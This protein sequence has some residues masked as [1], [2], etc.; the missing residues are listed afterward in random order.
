MELLQKIKS[1]EDFFSRQF[2]EK[3]FQ[4]LINKISENKDRIYPNFKNIFRIFEL[5]K[6]E[7]IK[8]I[9]LGQDPYHN[10]SQANG[11]AFGVNEN[12]VPP[13]SLRNINK[14]LINEYN[15]GL[16]D[17][18]LISWV[19]QGIFLINSIWTVI[20][21]QPLSCLDWGWDIFTKQL[22]KYIYELNNSVIFVCFGNWAFEY[23][24]NLNLKN[25]IIFKTSHPSPFSA[26]KGFIGSNIFKK[27]NNKLKE[28]NLKTINWC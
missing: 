7:D 28:M 11:I 15:T 8:V 13:P 9:V 20:K 5:I 1:W 3:Y 27:I 18:S 22:L 17:F 2:E 6:K 24:N 4:L 10:S 12:I 25:P 26:Y 19:N 21:N 14:E 23:I 16:K